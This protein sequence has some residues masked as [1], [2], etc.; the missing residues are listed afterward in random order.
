MATAGAL[1]G[2]DLQTDDV[3]MNAHRN[4]VHGKDN[5][6]WSTLTK[7]ELSTGVYSGSNS[8]SSFLD[9]NIKYRPAGGELGKINPT[10][11]SSYF[12]NSTENFAYHMPSSPSR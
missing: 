4:L 9:Q 6:S 12:G 7:T 8:V 2:I 10:V 11:D 3:I 5:N 1:N